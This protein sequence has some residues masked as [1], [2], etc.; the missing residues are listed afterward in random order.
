[1]DMNDN[2]NIRPRA[3]LMLV[4]KLLFSQMT[5]HDFQDPWKPKAK[6]E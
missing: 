3:S 5:D 4:F 1:M 2:V 6:K